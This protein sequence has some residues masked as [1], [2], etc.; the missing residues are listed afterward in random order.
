MERTIIQQLKVWK[1]KG[2]RK[3]LLL[4]GA[5]QIGKTWILK[6][7]GETMFQNMAYFSFDEEPALSDIFRLSKD[8]KRIVEQ[9]SFAKGLAIKPNETLIVLD[10]IQECPEALA[11]LKYFC[12]NAPEY[13]VAAAG[14]LLGI[15]FGHANY[16][17]PVGK[18]DHLDMFPLSFSEFLLAKDAVLYDY[19]NSINALESIPQL[20]FNRL[21]ETYKLYLTCG[22]MPAAVL[23]M[24]DGDSA[25]TDTVISNILKDYSLDMVK[26]STPVAANKIHYVWES[27]PSQLAKENRKFIYQLVR[28]GARAREYEDALMWLQNAGLVY[29]VNL[30]KEPAIPLKAYDDLSAFKIYTFDVGI[31]RC[32]ANIDATTFFNA[33]E[34]MKEFKGAMAENYVQQS[35]VVQYGKTLRYWSSGNEA[36][37]EFLLQTGNHIIPVEVKSGESVRSNSLVEYEKKYS[38]KLRLRYSLKNLTLDG[39]LLNIPLFLADLTPRFLDLAGI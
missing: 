20:F 37:I 29:R 5:R 22:G 19:F 25:A 3:P 28:P 4:F 11:S 23:K 9:L 24:I 6:H 34:K 38:P 33:D 35:L 31:L 2:D 39:N 21:S 15:S 7:F 14:S 18:V 27:L 13:A 17:F 12:E 8:P 16:S 1:E 36:E 26:H 10:E 30:C 32:L